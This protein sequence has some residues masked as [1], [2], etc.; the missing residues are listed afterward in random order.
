LIVVP[1]FA[2][3]GVALARR[4]VG[5]HLRLDLRPDPCRL[6]DDDRDNDRDEDKQPPLRL[7]C[8]SQANR[9]RSRQGSRQRSMKIRFFPESSS[10]ANG[11][12]DGF[13]AVSDE[14]RPVACWL[15]PFTHVGHD[16]ARAP[17]KQPFSIGSTIDCTLSQQALHQDVT[18]HLPQTKNRSRG[19][20]P[21][22]SLPFPFQINPLR[23][24]NVRRHGGEL[25]SLPCTA[26]L[27]ARS[28]RCFLA[29]LRQAG[30]WFAPASPSTVPT[31]Q[32]VGIAVVVCRL[33]HVPVDDYGDDYGLR[34]PPV[35]PFSFHSPTAAFTR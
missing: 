15:L 18:A 22:H 19:P 4:L 11:A 16:R 12:T 21:A 27:A 20:N 3:Q 24:A 33:S 1:I 10:Q 9:Q 32:R 28:F 13:G 25:A 23:R 26:L 29:R 8:S 31:S 14:Y 34:F 30:T 6:L 35:D 5:S 17:A 7:T 2:C